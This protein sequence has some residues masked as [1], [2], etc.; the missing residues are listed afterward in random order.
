MPRPLSW[1]PR[2]HAITRSVAHSVRSHYDRR[3]LEQLFELQPRAAQKLIE[4]LPAVKIGTS[5]LVEREALVSFL[6]RVR[7]TDDV[8]TLLHHLRQ[9]KEHLSRRKPRRLVRRDFDPIDL[10]S[11]PESLAL[12]RGRIE[13]SFLTVEQLA[14]NLFQ[15]AQL[16]TDDMEEFVTRFE[17]EPPPP[18][19][20]HADEV[21]QLFADLERMEAEHGLKRQRDQPPDSAE[22]TVPSPPSQSVAQGMGLTVIVQPSS[23]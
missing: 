1:L 21:Q 18:K 5:L 23:P 20:D 6:E 17:P 15:L 3:D 16:L 10:D 12:S 9:Q 4:M 11:L 7:E 8:P 19:I 2:L 22:T 14:Q 13:I